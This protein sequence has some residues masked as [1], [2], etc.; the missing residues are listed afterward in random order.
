MFVLLNGSFGIGKSTVTAL[1]AREVSAARIYDPE[2]VGYVLRRLPPWLIG[3]RRQPDDYQDMVLWRTL[4]ARGARRL[5]RRTPVVLV[6]MA[7]ANLDYLEAFADGLSQDG[8]VCRLC[9]V[10]P[11]DVVDERLRGRAA[12]EGREVTEF[13]W[14]RS[15]DCLA[16]HGDPRF[17]LPIDAG[18]SPERIAGLIR[19][20]AGI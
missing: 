19:A 5:H 3:L 13:E 17:G 16:A 7:F 6:P 18:G 4:I 11:A 15:R 20:A 12:A 1:L 14:R 10:A 2:N 9:M 8:P